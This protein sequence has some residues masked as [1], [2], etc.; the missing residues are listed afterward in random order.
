MSLT[1][2]YDGST[3]FRYGGTMFS[4]GEVAAAWYWKVGQLLPY[5]N[6]GL[7]KKF[8][9]DREMA[10]VNQAMWGL[11]PDSVWMD[12]P[13]RLREAEGKLRQ[14]QIAAEVG[15]T[16]PETLVTNDWEQVDQFLGRSPS[17]AAKMFQGMFADERDILM[18][19]Y[20]TRIDEARAR[21]LRGSAL[22]FPAMFQPFL[23]KAREWRI[24]VVGDRVFSA[25]IYTGSSAKDDWRRLQ[26]TD[27]V[28][29]E[30][31]RAP[32]E[33]SELCK[34]Y[35]LRQGLRFGAFDLVETTEGGVVFLECN[36]VG[37][38]AWLEDELELSISAAVAEE[39]VSV[40]MRRRSC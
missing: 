25:A 40:A 2:G 31:E 17:L 26:L 7:L 3:Q 18:A 6:G 28:R 19:T 10:R 5:E 33:I 8:S 11:L 16:I 12:P 29:F 38:F 20:T 34:A 9:I 35:C 39:I 13:Q 32:E 23:S 22:P 4:L 37:Q 27:A 21:G 36:P 1:V 30:A 14:L 24:T 15:F